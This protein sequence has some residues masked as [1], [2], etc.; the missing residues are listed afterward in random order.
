MKPFYKSIIALLAAC[1]LHA[2][3]ADNETAKGT[4][5][6]YS[7]VAMADENGRFA[8][9]DTSDASRLQSSR[10]SSPT[11]GKPYSALEIK[12]MVRA[13]ADGNQLT[14]RVESRLFRDSA[15][16]TRTETE[17][18]GQKLIIITDP[19]AQQY[20]ALRPEQ[21]SALR[22]SGPRP[23]PP[24]RV[25]DDKPR[26]YTGMMKYITDGDKAELGEREIEGIPARGYKLSFE[27][28][29]GAVGNELAIAITS[30]TW[31]ATGGWNMTLR[32][33]GSDPRYGDENLTLSDIKQG[34]Q[35]L[36]LFT[37]PENIKV[38]DIIT[39]TVK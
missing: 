28:P 24:P 7:I 39:T 8:V 19:V 4:A 16:R 35:P 31:T 12:E 15:G 10:I 21:G 36:S 17:V 9:D 37:L 6:S 38:R 22:L 34:E 3:A 5:T 2:H 11:K 30:E 25:P 26:E 20:Y 18:R 27:I 29:A 13:L 1:G 33:K 23:P 32:R 14:T